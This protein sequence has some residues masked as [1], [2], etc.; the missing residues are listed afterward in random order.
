MRPGDRV[1]A[2]RLL[3]A[4]I[5]AVIF[6]ADRWT[7]HLVETRMAYGDV[8]PVFPLFNLTYVT[9]TGA[10]FGI[11]E[12]RNKFF[13]GISVVVLIAIFMVARKAG[14]DLRI[15]A[16]IALIVGGALG[17]LYDR[18]TRGYV[19]DFLDFYAGSRHWPA[20]NVADSA[21]LVGALGVALLEFKKE[22]GI[23]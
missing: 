19:T 5:A 9:N 21:I 2:V 20:F 14:S 17:N 12:D 8:L 4:A 6:G 11:G 1:K 22:E 13:I 23:K 10:A 15:K 3:P 18:I 16:A 7:K